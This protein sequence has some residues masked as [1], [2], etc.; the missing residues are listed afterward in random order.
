MAQNSSTSI[1]RLLKL[2]IA[3]LLAVMVVLVFGNVVLRYGFNSGITVSE[4]LSRWLWSG[5]RSSAPSS[6]C[7][8]TPI[9]AST[10]WFALAA[11]RQ[12]YLLRP[13]LQPDALRRLAAADRELAAELHHHRRPRARDRLPVGLFYGAGIVFGVSA[14]VILIDDLS[15]VLAPGAASEEELVAVRESEEL[16]QATDSA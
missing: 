2:I 4:E 15:R 9:S 10:P 6:R 3:V 1:A 11:A 16:V 7:A 14:G 8:S 13:E 12:A 5:S